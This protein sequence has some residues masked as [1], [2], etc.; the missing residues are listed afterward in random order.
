VQTQWTVEEVETLTL[1][2]LSALLGEDPDALRHQLIQKGAAM[3]VDSLDM[4]D[5]L[6]DFRDRTGLTIPKA[7]LRRQTLKSVHT[8]A[9]FVVQEARP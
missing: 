3:P 9:E 4:F 8:F 6:K 2:L 7:K 1:E 5:I